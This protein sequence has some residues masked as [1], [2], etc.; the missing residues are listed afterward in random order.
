MGV[1]RG[2]GKGRGGRTDRGREPLLLSLSLF[3]S[4]CMSGVVHACLSIFIA[5]SPLSTFPVAS[6]P[7]TFVHVICV[8]THVLCVHTH[9]HTNAL[10]PILTKAVTCVACMHI[11]TCMHVYTDTRIG[12]HV[13]D[14]ARA[15]PTLTTGGASAKTMAFVFVPRFGGTGLFGA[16][17]VRVSGE[18]CVCALT[19]VCVGGGGRVCVCVCVCTRSRVRVS[20][21]E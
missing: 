13:C 19:H 3:L 10:P 17:K 18:D 15:M 5:S 20:A 6:P 7:P 4:L 9:V 21:S 16:T 14:Y 11:P 8:H 2:R 1:G 12:M